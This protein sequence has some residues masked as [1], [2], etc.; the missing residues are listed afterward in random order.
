[1]KLAPI[2]LLGLA[3]SAFDTLAAEATP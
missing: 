2:L 3:F 1:M